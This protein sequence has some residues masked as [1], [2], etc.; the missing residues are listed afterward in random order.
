MRNK[1]KHNVIRD[2]KT[3]LQPAM[4]PFKPHKMEKN[5]RL[6]ASVSR[7]EASCN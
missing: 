7:M 2:A 5:V 1:A 4:D 6:Q 3:R